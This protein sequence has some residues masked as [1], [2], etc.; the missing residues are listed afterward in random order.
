M[1]TGRSS[2][3]TAKKNVTKKR[4]ERKEKIIEND[5]GVRESDCW[6]S[7]IAICRRSFFHLMNILNLPNNER[8][9]H[10]IY[11]LISHFNFNSDPD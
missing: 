8:E 4:N 10:R 1:I 2:V 5:F 11:P 9:I 6:V 7:E 3:E